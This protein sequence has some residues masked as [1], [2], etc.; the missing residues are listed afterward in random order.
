MTWLNIP[1]NYDDYV[2]F[3]YEI[4]EINTGMKYIGKTNFWYIEKKK[5][6]KYVLENGKYKKDKKGKRILNTR[7]T[8]KH[9]KKE[10]DWRNYNSSSSILQNKIETN[11]SN[12]IKK[13]LVC[14]KSQS[15]LKAEEAYL[16]LKAWKEG[17]WD[18]YYNEII[19]L[20]I[21]FPSKK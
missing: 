18:K 9:V 17:N 13:I 6:T 7:T 20:R 1:N 3:V 12:Y 15:E 8:K 16:Q 11:P 19:N 5:P 21:T 4:T 2:G 14:H 10:S